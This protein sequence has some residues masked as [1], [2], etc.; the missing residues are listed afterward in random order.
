VW[1]GR[2]V[3]PRSAPQAFAVHGAMRLLRAVPLLTR[4]LERN[5]IKP[6]NRFR[7]GLLAPGRA[8]GGLVRGGL[9]PQALL[10]D[11]AGRQQPSDE[12]LGAAVSCVGL[13]VDFEQHLSAQTRAAFLARGGRFVRLTTRRPD[14]ETYADLTGTFARTLRAGHIA[15]VRPDRALLHDGPA[16]R[17]EQILRE[18]IVLLGEPHRETDHAARIALR[19]RATDPVG[20]AAR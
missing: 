16:Q 7:S 17:A 2:L 4:R 19:A 13:D 20:P 1:M 10:Q 18:S 3:M 5:D 9:F 14:R 8:G 15:V 11:E 12:L 6:P